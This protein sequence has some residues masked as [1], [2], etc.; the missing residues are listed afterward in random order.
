VSAA[1]R[2]PRLTRRRA[3]AGIAAC[4]VLRPLVSTAAP[5]PAKLPRIGVLCADEDPDYFWKQLERIGYVEHRTIE[6]V[7]KDMNA[8][9]DITGYAGRLVAANVD[10]IVTCSN[11]EAAAA[12]RA[13]AQIPIVLLYGVVPVE[14]GLVAS[15]A[16]PGGNLTGS[17]AIS[18]G[19]AGKAVGLLASAVPAMRRLA[20]VADV[21]NPIGAVLRGAA[22][23]AAQALGL[24]VTTVQ[25]RD[26]AGV[27]AALAELARSRPDGML[28][29]PSVYEHIPDLIEFAARQRLPAMYPFAPAVR[30]GGLMAYA[31]NW[32]PQSERN[33]RIVDR[34]LKGEHPRDIPMEQPLQYAFA[35]NLK[36]ARAMG[37]AIPPPVLLQATS[38]VE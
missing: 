26:A 21:D 32:I 16:R 12:K 27:P 25:L 2:R 1:E 11:A 22:R 10:V 9:A 35:I 14:V 34:I 36:T 13:T 31:P 37:L 23:R 33:A 38:V 15:L 18:T 24:E 29:V 30:A 8:S 7:F 3:V 28:V 17:A 5:S 19:M 4:C 20:I 6:Y